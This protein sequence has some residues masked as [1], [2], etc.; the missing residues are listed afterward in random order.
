MAALAAVWFFAFEACAK[1]VGKDEAAAAVRGW[2]SLPGRGLRVV[3]GNEVASAEVFADAQGAPLYYVL[4]LKPSG[5][6]IA[7]ADDLVEPI[8]CFSGS[9]KYVASDENPLGALVNRDIPKRIAQAQAQAARRGEAPPKFMLDAQQKWEQVRAVASAPG[10]IPK[11]LL[12]ISDLRVE[13]LIQSRWSQ[14]TLGDDY[15]YNYYTPNHYVCGCVATAMSQLMRFW[16]H[17]SAAVGTASFSITVDQTPG[18]A[19]LRGGDGNGGPYDWA[20]M[21]LDPGSI[22]ADT[23]R[24]AI[25]A[26]CSDAGVAAHMN[27]AAAGSGAGPTDAAAAL[28]NVFL[29]SNCICGFGHN[30]N[31]GAG[32][33][34]MLNPNL[35]AGYP[36][37]LSILSPGHGHEIVADGYGY[38]TSTLYYHLNLGWAGCCDAWY[39]LPAFTAGDENWNSVPCCTYNIYVSGNG[40]IIS[41]RITDKADAPINGATVTAACAGGGTYT[42][43]SNRRGIYALPKVPAQSLYTISVKAPGYAFAS[44]DVSTGTS[45]DA[46]ATSGNVWAVNFQ[47]DPAASVAYV[48]ATDTADEQNAQSNKL[49]YAMGFVIGQSLKE[50]A[51]K[52]GVGWLLVGL[53]DGYQGNQ[54]LLSETDSKAISQA[55]A[56]KRAGSGGE[57]PASA[58]GPH[59]EFKNRMEAASAEMKRRMGSGE[60]GAAKAATEASKTP[61][62]SPLAGILEALAKG[63]AAGVPAGTEGAGVDWSHAAPALGTLSGTEVSSA[64]RDLRGL[65]SM[66][67]PTVAA[68][69]W[70]FWAVIIGVSKYKD[71]RIPQLRYAAADAKAFYDWIVS[72][73]GGRY[74]PSNVKLLLDEEAT[75]QNIRN[76]LFTWL[77]Q[78][79]KED[80]ILIY[81]SGHGAPDSSEGD[82]AAPK[83]LFL[84][85]HDTQADAIATTGFPMWDVE[86]VLKR[87]V[88]AQKVVVIADA[89]HSGGVGSAI[90]RATRDGAASKPNRISAAFQ[91]L[92]KIG[93]GVCVISASDDN[94]YSLEG[95]E[96]GGG[97]GV[98]TYFLLQGL[99]GGAD[100]KQDGHVTLGELIPYLSEQVRRAT[101][102]SQA[103][104]V[105]GRFDPALAVGR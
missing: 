73:Q 78:A 96:W 42:A 10:V 24:Q 20:E 52:F 30:R 19:N 81:F 87:F 69:N 94:Q 105:A 7:P 3:L 31:I 45:A 29:Y 47:G 72:P 70:Q 57:G 90:M 6:V 51:D 100:Y 66:S 54:S 49:G 23:Q 40:E 11:G 98:F 32:L 50:S 12:S 59:D 97:H 18:T 53:L 56:A 104:V 25:G 71:S 83:N 76:T 99:S 89:C 22:A 5:Y 14:D 77:K 9:G 80:V 8:V 33:S 48:G 92:T 88:K 41:G 44:R 34:D 103:P 67:G 26:L 35:D 13:P 79:I 27:Y 16:Q 1:P 101:Q 65:G 4:Y 64:T 38:D 2:L 61:P 74:A 36:C 55:I 102:S 82:N 86:T 84:I 39:N 75:T 58:A 43:V 21:K 46:Q 37:L 63:M 15:C 17:P 60:S 91:D 93:N 95:T 28:K 62:A 68:P 85:T